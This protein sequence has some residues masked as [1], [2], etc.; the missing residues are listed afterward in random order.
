MLFYYPRILPDVIFADPQV[1]LDKVTE[2]VV[3]SFERKSKGHSDSWCKFY[4]FALVTVE[5]LT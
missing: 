5:F 1:I 3:A 4:E 2:L